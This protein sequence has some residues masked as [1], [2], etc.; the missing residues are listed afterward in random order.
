MTQGLKFKRSFCQRELWMTNRHMNRSLMSLIKSE[1]PIKTTIWL[2]CTPIRIVE[3]GRKG[4]KEGQR[5]G[6]KHSCFPGSHQQPQHV[7]PPTFSKHWQNRIF[8]IPEELGS[9]TIILH[10]SFI[11]FLFSFLLTPEP[12][13][14]VHQL[15]IIT[16]CVRMTD[17]CM[18]HQGIFWK[19]LEIDNIK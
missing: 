1:V 3:G 2:H 17:T 4:G 5:N 15:H 14:L 18:R 11:Y 13:S 9:H 19:Y 7:A 12:L 8:I 10:P 6:M 16:K